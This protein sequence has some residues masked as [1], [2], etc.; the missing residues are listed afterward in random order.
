MWVWV[1]TVGEGVHQDPTTLDC[2]LVG[3]WRRDASESPMSPSSPSL[4]EGLL[5]SLLRP[6]RGRCMGDR[7]WMASLPLS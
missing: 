2:Q 1:G 4:L 3:R 7:G 5:Y 6:P